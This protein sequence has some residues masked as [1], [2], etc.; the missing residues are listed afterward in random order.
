MNVIELL[1]ELVAIDS[2]NPFK[3]IVKD[4]K[5]IGIGNE[6]KI[7]EY[8][9]KK[10]INN[11]FSVKRQFVQEATTVS[12]GGNVIT[13][14]ERYNLL[15]SKGTGNKSLLFLG[16]MDTV[17]VKQGWETNP[18]EAVEK[19]VNGKQIICGL[20]ANDMKA[21]LAAILAGVEDEDVTD[22]I[23]KIAF[24]CDEEF[25]SYGAVTLLESSFLDDVTLVVS[26]E[27]GDFD[28]KTS[29]QAIVLGRM[30]R[31]EY[32]F[33]I[34]GIACHGA[35]ARTNK[36]AV[37]AV[38]ESVKLQHYLIDYCKNNAKTFSHGGLS[39]TN[40]AY[41][42]H[43][44]GGKAIL[45]VPDKASFI[46]DRSFV[47]NEDVESELT[48]L[49]QLVTEAYK[50]NI[51]DQRAI[52]SVKLRNRPT[53]PCK[54]YFFPPEHEA[55][56]FVTRCVDSIVGAHEEGIGYSVSDENRLAEKGIPSIVI[57]PLGSRSHAPQE[58][59]DRES[60]LKLVDIY[61]KIINTFGSDM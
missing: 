34:T 15:A 12:Q 45:S 25:W 44:Q 20:G 48:I 58:W 47:M 59:V 56:Q 10:L 22:Y 46:L 40:S 21:G 3:T 4:G 31:S 32:L 33:E 50:Q 30:G 49:N 19:E 9:E 38:H 1:K 37:N 53:L 60:L 42:S 24:V 6:V 52:V 43:H 61:K 51:I 11:G 41:I 13:I 26:P 28:R 17:D 54:P 18:F 27:I 16:H 39:M 35:Q 55:V 7:A 2:T 57:G 36:E 5:E 8:L 29:N 14:P 23:L